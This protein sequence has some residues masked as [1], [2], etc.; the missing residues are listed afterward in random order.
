MTCSRCTRRPTSLLCGKLI[1]P[2]GLARG[3][4]P[5]LEGAWFCFMPTIMVAQGGTLLVRAR[6]IQQQHRG[7]PCLLAIEWVVNAGRAFFSSVDG[8][9]G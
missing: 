9:S 5:Q 3:Q 6:L 7:R 2:H 4:I 8:W 1:S